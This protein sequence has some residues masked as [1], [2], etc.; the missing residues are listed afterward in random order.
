VSR[1]AWIVSAMTVLGC[2]ERQAR[3][4]TRRASP[5]E[6]AIARDLTAR[7]G[8]SVTV[9]CRTLAGAPTGCSAKLA[10]GTSMSIVMENASKDEWG[11]RIDGRVIESK[12]I[13]AYVQEQLATIGGKQTA[14]CGP[15]IAVVKAGDRIACALSGG[16]VAFV[17]IAPDGTTTLELDLDATSAAARAEPVTPERERELTTR[18]K[19]LETLEWESDGEEQVPADA[20]VPPR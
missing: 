12:T 15:P 7:F 1:T 17:Q 4:N 10:D 16:G 9:T 20:G 19:A 11:W 14:A 3:E 18:S 2:S 8:T 5:V 6:T 13:A